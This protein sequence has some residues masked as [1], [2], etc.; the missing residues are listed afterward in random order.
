MALCN[1]GLYACEQHR[2][3]QTAE[4]KH[5]LDFGIVA[6]AL[7]AADCK[8]S[9]LIFDTFARGPSAEPIRA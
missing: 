5:S 4:W 1:R 2:S 7:F 8:D 3:V 9:D 6:D